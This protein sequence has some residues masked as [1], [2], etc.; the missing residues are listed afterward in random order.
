MT[1]PTPNAEQILRRP[2]LFSFLRATWDFMFRLRREKRLA[3]ISDPRSAQ[4]LSRRS[5]QLL[6][7]F[8]AELLPSRDPGPRCFLVDTL[9]QSGN[10]HSTNETAVNS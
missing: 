7:H 9:R 5:A 2:R 4:A 3:L 6:L 10:A 1:V 8:F